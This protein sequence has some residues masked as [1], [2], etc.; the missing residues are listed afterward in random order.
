MPHR[1]P[2]PASFYAA[3]VVG[4]VVTAA[5]AFGQVMDEKFR[6]DAPDG[7]TGSKFGFAVAMDGGVLAVGVPFARDD[8]IGTGAVY[9]FDAGTGE[10]LAKLL[11]SDRDAGDEFGCS[12]A[13][14][15][16]VVAIGAKRDD[17]NGSDSG[18][19]YLFDVATGTQFAKLLADDGAV[20]DNFGG[21]I[22]I[23]DGVVVVG[24]HGHFYGFGAAYVYEASTGD[25]V[26]KLMATYGAMGD[27]FGASVAIEGGRIAVGAPNRSHFGKRTGA[28]YMFDASGGTQL[29]Q[30]IPESWNLFA[31]FGAS[32]A[33]D[34]GVVAVGADR[35]NGGG[36]FSSG[37]GFLFDAD[38]GEQLEMLVAADGAANDKLGTSIAIH[39]GVVVIGAVGADDNGSYSGSAYLFDASTGAQSAELLPSDGAAEDWFGHAVTVFDGVVGVGAPQADVESGTNAG[40]VYVFDAAGCAPDLNGDGQV[41]TQDFLAFLNAWARG[42]AVADWNR[43][44]RFDTQDVVAFLNDWAAGCP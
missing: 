31:R 40:S 1:N 8:G 17:D 22:A 20:N 15:G 28:A 34:G 25:Q 33:M 18:A 9:L 5:T 38:S 16:G 11:P 21:A 26:S 41:N 42:D 19:A 35:Q 44:G 23:N 24:A 2:R 10:Q 13:M 12:V 3:F 36:V 6:I 37:A 39:D 43:D 4:C 7:Q 27:F 29:F 14:H 32:I 30:L